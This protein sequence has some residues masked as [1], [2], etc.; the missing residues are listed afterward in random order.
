VSLD[1]WEKSRNDYVIAA[2][3]LNQGNFLIEI[4]STTEAVLNRTGFSARV[5]VRGFLV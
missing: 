1:R 4:K 3:S 5:R 2:G